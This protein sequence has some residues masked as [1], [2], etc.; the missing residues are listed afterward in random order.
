MLRVIGD[1]DELLCSLFRVFCRDSVYRNDADEDSVAVKITDFS[2]TEVL[3][4]EF[5]SSSNGW[6]AAWY[7]VFVL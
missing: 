5:G 2:S 3:F 7:F 6:M 4:Q 1:E